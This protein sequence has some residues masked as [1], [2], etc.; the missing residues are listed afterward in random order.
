MEII[1][2]G[3]N[4]AEGAELYLQ[5][6]DA[7]GDPIRPTAVF[8][9]GESIRLTFEEPPAPGRYRAYVKNPG[10]LES[11]LE[12]IV[13]P[14]EPPVAEDSGPA[15]SP[16]TAEDSRR[17]FDIY[18]TAAYSPLIPLY[19]Y[20]F[21][22][23]DASFSLGG[24]SARIGFVF[25]KPSRGDLGLEL[26]PSWNML[27]ADSITMHL[28]PLHVNGIYQLWLPGEKTL[29]FRLGAGIN[30]IYGTNSDAQ[31]EGSIFTWMPSVNGGIA[32]RWFVQGFQN[33]RWITYRTLYFEIGV[34]YTHIFAADSPQPGY[35]RPF[36]GIGWRF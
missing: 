35:I 20:L 2:H 36:L 34:D 33:F 1:L 10:G 27:K 31:N 6:I 18:V 4:F 28:Y 3:R 26:A 24:A 9:S 19:G 15:V 5:P 30:L 22:Q 11:S 21:E 23:I 8:S 17:P 16:D 13:E 25:S 29:I 32:F 12:I 14:P 7:V